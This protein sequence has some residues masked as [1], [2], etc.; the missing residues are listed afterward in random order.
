MANL[1]VARLLGA[2]IILTT[3]LFQSSLTFGDQIPAKLLPE[4]SESGS[5]ACSEAKNA[6]EPLLREAALHVS[7][8]TR[9]NIENWI[10]QSQSS[11]AKAWSSAAVGFHLQFD[12]W[13]A[14]WTGLRAVDEVWGGARIGQV[15]VYLLYV[16]NH[17]REAEDFIA[18][19]LARGQD[20]MEIREARATLLER[21]GRP[22]EAKQEIR[23]ARELAPYDP[24]LKLEEQ[25][26]N[27]EDTSLPHWTATPL[28]DC[29]E[30]LEARNR[31]H[32]EFASD[33]EKS[34][35]S[36]GGEW[37]QAFRRLQARS[38]E[39]FELKA[40]PAGLGGLPVP[41]EQTKY[42]GQRMWLAR[43]YWPFRSTTLKFWYSITED[44][45]IQNEREVRLR[46]GQ[47]WTSEV[48]DLLREGWP[49]MRL[50]FINSGIRACVQA[51]QA[52]LFSEITFNLN[53]GTS[54][55]FYASVASKPFSSFVR[56]ASE[57]SK[58]SPRTMQSLGGPGA[59]SFP[60]IVR[61]SRD[62][63]EA[64]NN[65]EAL[66]SG[67]T[68]W[69]RQQYLICQAT[70]P[71]YRTWKSGLERRYNGL[72][73]N[74]PI[75]AKRLMR[76]LEAP[77]DEAIAFTTSYAISMI[78]GPDAQ[79]REKYDSVYQMPFDAAMKSIDDFM[80]D[81]EKMAKQIDGGYKGLQENWD[82]AQ[83]II[84]RE[85]QRLKRCL[86]NPPPVGKIQIEGL[87]WVDFFAQFEMPTHSPPHCDVQLGNF[88]AQLGWDPKE[89]RPYAEA[90]LAKGQKIFKM[91]GAAQRNANGIRT[92][93][94][95]G[96]GTSMIPGTPFVVKGDFGIQVESNQSGT[97]E[98]NLVYAGGIGVGAMFKVRELGVGIS[99]FPTEVSGSIPLAR[100]HIDELSSV[101]MKFAGGVL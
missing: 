50:A 52:H 22:S 29:V 6:M 43:T 99:C 72:L 95:R 16:G 36:V 32:A 44:E 70:V 33:R 75:Q 93:Q 64:I 20:T 3:V 38:Q 2:L 5:M 89:K 65:V 86:A 74:Y 46:Q 90:G 25:L 4:L 84:I 7:A 62:Y 53:Y 54:W 80:F 10:E 55:E 73:L 49:L 11:T 101:H 60:S 96:A 21:L 42:Y 17:D 27:G 63:S 79:W 56:E 57:V 94:L 87:G 19:A 66:Y 31:R 85:E 67:V 23:K 45:W 88:A 13:S 78:H 18:C 92:V 81:V 47:S 48:E 40:Y 69:E 51:Y 15:G 37:A 68:P 41:P 59:R 61:I 28:G 82:N 83:I 26:V 9:G 8:G 35:N 1:L 34:W 76:S 91:E 97:G 98:A 58:L 14:L 24:I 77:I 12:S 100:A 30:A 71:Y 39:I